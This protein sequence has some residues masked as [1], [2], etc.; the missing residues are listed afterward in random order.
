MTTLGR[1]ARLR[2]AVL[3]AITA[4]GL[5]LGAGLGPA[6]A[7][8]ATPVTITYQAEGLPAGLTTVRARHVATGQAVL[9]S[10]ATILVGTSATG[11]LAQQTVYR[12]Q[13]QLALAATTSPIAYQY[14]VWATG[15]IF[16]RP[17]ARTSVFERTLSS[18]QATAGAATFR[19][20]LTAETASLVEQASG[21]APTAA[22]RATPLHWVTRHRNAFGADAIES[23]SLDFRRNLPI[24]A[25]NPSLGKLTLDLDG[26]ARRPEVCVVTGGQRDCSPNLGRIGALGG[27]A[28]TLDL[29]RTAFQRNGDDL[30]VTWA[31]QLGSSLPTGTLVATAAGQMETR[32]VNTTAGIEAKRLLTWR[33]LRLGVAVS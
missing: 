27:G 28:L 14:E 8:A 5:L 15:E 19:D 2:P 3:S 10:Q 29:H 26:P 22:G 6:P 16:V 23:V 18:Q 17:S 21:L 9:L 25:I 1:M 32:L 20:A 33:S 4:L 11:T 12:G 7:L 30:V 31:F 24:G 13:Q